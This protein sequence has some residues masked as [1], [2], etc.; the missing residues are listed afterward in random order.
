[1]LGASPDSDFVLFGHSHIQFRKTVAGLDYI[2]VGSVGQN[3]C[4]KLL[5][6]YGVIQD[7]VFEHRQVSYDPAP[8]IHALDQVEA[9]NDFPELRK[10]F[11]DSLL[12]GFGTGRKEP[13]IRYAAEGYF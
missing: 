9:L 5:A 8:W 10:W 6:C 12:T 7:G 4:G 13:W 1:M 2:N 11:R 3:R